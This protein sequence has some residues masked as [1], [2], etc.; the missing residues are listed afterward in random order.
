MQVFLK[1]KKK[2]E[3]I[4]HKKYKNLRENEKQKLA[5]CLKK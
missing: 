3:T 1:K 2:K 4:C 5:K